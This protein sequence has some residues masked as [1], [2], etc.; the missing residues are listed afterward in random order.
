MKSLSTPQGSLPPPSLVHSITPLAELVEW[1]YMDSVGSYPALKVIREREA[2]TTPAEGRAAW[3]SKYWNEVK[4]KI[5]D[6]VES[7]GIGELDIEVVFS[8]E[9]FALE[10]SWFRWNDIERTVAS[11]I[12]VPRRRKELVAQLAA[13]IETPTNEGVE[14]F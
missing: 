1:R 8:A 5:L 14:L 9:Q 2:G 12:Q 7:E 3:C 4:G 6:V 10:P 11:G 13:V